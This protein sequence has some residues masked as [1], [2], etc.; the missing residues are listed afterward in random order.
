MLSMMQTMVRADN[1]KIVRASAARD[2]TISVKRIL[3]NNS[4]EPKKAEFIFAKEMESR[5]M[6]LI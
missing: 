3:H 4:I 2:D 6:Q 5:K 1:C